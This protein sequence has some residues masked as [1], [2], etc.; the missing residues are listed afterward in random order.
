M[1]RNTASNSLRESYQESDAVIPR[2]PELPLFRARASGAL[3]EL[4]E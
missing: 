1:I 2:P 4:S 3:R